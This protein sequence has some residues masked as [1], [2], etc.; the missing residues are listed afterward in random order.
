MAS[1]D[2]ER[3]SCSLG[4]SNG[5][6]LDDSG[7]WLARYDSLLHWSL[8]DNSVGLSDDWHWWQLDWNLGGGLLEV[9]SSGATELGGS[10]VLNELESVVLHDQ[11]GDS[12]HSFSE[13]VSGV[14]VDA[15]VDDWRDDW[16]DANF[17]FVDD[18][19]DWLLDVLNLRWALNEPSASEVESIG[20][21]VG[22]VASPAGLVEVGVADWIQR[23]IDVA[24][25]KSSWV[26]SDLEV[27]GS[28][29]WSACWLSWSSRNWVSDA[30]DSNHFK[31]TL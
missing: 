1:A 6:A 23:S 24:G 2:S 19:L 25:G 10:L 7:N 21:D 15:V 9:D 5:L 22:S 26:F 31:D 11:E 4:D 29:G 3:S 8:G 20:D 13:N 14:L 16:S 28:R 18:S 12:G 30:V 27:G 17:V